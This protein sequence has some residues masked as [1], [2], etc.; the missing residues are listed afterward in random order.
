MSF[1]SEFWRSAIVP[2][3]A[4]FGFSAQMNQTNPPIPKFGPW[5]KLNFTSNQQWPCGKHKGMRFDLFIERRVSCHP[6]QIATSV[7]INTPTTA[8]WWE[9]S[10]QV[11]ALPTRSR[12]HSSHFKSGRI[13]SLKSWRLRLAPRILKIPNSKT[14]QR[15]NVYIFLR[16]GRRPR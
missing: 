5:P 4:K 8:I 6:A 16:S 12:F 2:R 10:C 15:F 11:V 14:S 13:L 9:K 3:S 7:F 1:V